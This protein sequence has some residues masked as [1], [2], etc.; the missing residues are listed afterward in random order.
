V[1]TY[2]GPTPRMPSRTDLRVVFQALGG[3]QRE[4]DWWITNLECNWY[5]PGFPL[6]KTKFLNGD[7]LTRVVEA[8]DVQFVWAVLSG[9]AKG[10]K[11]DTH[12]APPRADAEEEVIQHPQAVV[13]IRCFDSSSTLLLSRDDDLTAR[14]R[15]FFP[16]AFDLGEYHGRARE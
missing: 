6:E 16:E 7:E 5:P 9:F 10:S 14:F 8:H 4:F 12:C 15:A 3:R 11:V 13:E 2:L 1:N